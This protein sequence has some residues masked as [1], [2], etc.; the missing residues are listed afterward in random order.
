V[1]KLD[2]AKKEYRASRR[3]RGRVAIPL[4]FRRMARVCE[5]DGY[6]ANLAAE[7]RMR[8]VG[9]NSGVV[10]VWCRFV[11]SERKATWFRCLERCDTSGIKRV[12]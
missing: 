9:G 3:N 8:L 11:G 10:L 7:L 12:Y 6:D 4:L 5:F 2:S 1:L